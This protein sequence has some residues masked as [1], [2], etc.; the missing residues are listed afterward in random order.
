ME[1]TWIRIREGSREEFKIGHR[2]YS[3]FE[4]GTLAQASGFVETAAYGDVEGGPY[5]ETAS[6]LVLLA[7][8]A[9]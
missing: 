9:E 4:L 6:R 7:R 3:A 2:L 5:D 8:R 1:N